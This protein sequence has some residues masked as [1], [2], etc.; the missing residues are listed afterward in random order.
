MPGPQSRK[1]AKSVLP[2]RRCARND[3]M[4]AGRIAARDVA[5]A[6]CT[7]SSGGTPL[8]K[9]P[10]IDDG[11]NNDPTTDPYQAR[12]QPGACARSGAQSDQRQNVQLR[13]PSAHSDS[14]F[15][16]RDPA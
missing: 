12:Q 10:V 2:A 7:A 5:T 1:N 9:K 14:Q 3:T 8:L 16:G 11:D 13:P 4:A 15:S 6:T